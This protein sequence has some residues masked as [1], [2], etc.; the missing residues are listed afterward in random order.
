MVSKLPRK[1]IYKWNTAHCRLLIRLTLDVGLAAAVAISRGN[2]I[3]SAVSLRKLHLVW[4]NSKWHSQTISEELWCWEYERASRFSPLLVCDWHQTCTNLC[5][6]FPTISKILRWHKQIWLGVGV[7]LSPYQIMRANQ[8]TAE[9]K[10]T[11]KLVYTYVTSLEFIF[12]Q[13]V[14]LAF[15]YHSN[16]LLL[17]VQ[18]ATNMPYGND[19][20]DLSKYIISMSDHTSTNLTHTS[21]TL[22]ATLYS[23]EHGIRRTVSQSQ[24]FLSGF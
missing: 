4:N 17:S 10:L 15:V 18:D 14:I 2:L 24:L 12:P 20:F 23:M 11:D 22:W 13:S 5:V 16:L 8:F 6:H 7:S 19:T 1:L 9:Q 21:R 3:W